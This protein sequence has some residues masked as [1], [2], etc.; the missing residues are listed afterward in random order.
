MM[1]LN[2]KNKLESAAELR[3]DSILGVIPFVELKGATTNVRIG[4]TMFDL[5][6]D[7][8]VSGRPMKLLA[9]IKTKAE[10]R[11]VR[12]AALQLKSRVQT[13]K[14]GFGILVA[15]FISPEAIQICREAGIG[16]MDLCGNVFLSFGNIFI[17]KSGMPNAFL[18][19]R[20]LKSL[21]SPKTSRVLRALLSNP[22]KGWYVEELSKVADISLGLASKAK[23]ELLSQ[24]WIREE[25][26]RVILCKP[27]QLLDEWAKNYTYKKNCL[28]SFYSGDSEQALETA[29]KSECEKSGY[30]Y[31]LALFSG[32]RRVAPFVRFPKFFFYVEGPIADIVEALRLKKVESGANVT[33]LEPYDAGVFQGLQKI[34]GMNVVSDIQLYLDLRSYG[35]RGDEAAQAIFEQRIKPSW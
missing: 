23:Q 12:M 4:D 19:A 28:S 2:Y 1:K 13:I 6:V 25:G 14:N 31:A 27:L 35:A 10:P 11:F 9:E 32:A 17:E 22:S 26:R 3:L 8:V 20:P 24:E 5:M 21:F 29:I 30:R 34:G 33:L 15:P 16:C 18:E 7:V